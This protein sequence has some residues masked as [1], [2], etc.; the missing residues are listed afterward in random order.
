MKSW[1]KWSEP[2]PSGYGNQITQADDIIGRLR[3]PHG[4]PS[5]FYTLS[6]SLR[7]DLIA[8]L[9][10]QETVILQAG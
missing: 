4:I 7:S 1:L 6:F 5:S 3:I 9:F 8:L 10:S 2:R